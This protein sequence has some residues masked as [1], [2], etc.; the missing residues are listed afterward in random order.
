MSCV[1]RGANIGHKEPQ[2]D[3]DIH[4]HT[5]NSFVATNFYLTHAF[6][7]H[8][9]ILVAALNG[10]AVGG[11]AAIAAFADFI[12]ASPHTY[13]LTPFASLGL[14]AEI[15]T[16][17]TLVQRL[18]ISL[19]NEAM[20]MGRKITARELVKC[21]FIYKTVDVEE[22]NDRAFIDKVMED[23]RERFDGAQLNGESLLQIKSL[24]RGPSRDALAV[25]NVAEVFAGWP[26]VASG[27]VSEEMRK[28]KAGKK[29]HK[30]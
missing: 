29:R 7:R 4:R 6:A 26:R 2:T 3:P 9:K 11:S 22:G 16:S 15:G 30:L 13:I 27:A 25:Q 14:V 1:Y 10:P 8:S 20:L 17:Y 19:A 21:G 18:G 5:L 23:L 12:Y 28:I 24:V